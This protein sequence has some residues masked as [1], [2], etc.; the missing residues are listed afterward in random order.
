MEK[1]ASAPPPAYG[2]AP[3]AYNPAPV[4]WQQPTTEYLQQGA[5][6]LQQQT[7]F[8]QPPPQGRFQQPPSQTSFQQYPQQAQMAP[9]SGWQ[10]QPGGPQVTTVTYAQQPNVLYIAPTAAAITPGPHKMRIQ[11]PS[12]HA[13]VETTVDY[14]SGNLAWIICAVIAI[15]G[16]FFLIP[17]LFC[18]I[19][20]VIQD[21]KNVKHYCPNCKHY[22]GEYRRGC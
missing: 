21:C 2:D 18:W 1:G 4:G 7:G 8:Q 14:E 22:I 17:F 10:P 3:P 19:P 16:I 13:Q 20:F 9:P 5:P 11:C 12:C 6:P 15:L